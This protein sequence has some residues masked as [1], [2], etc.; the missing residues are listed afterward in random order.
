MLD[1]G[2]F[3]DATPATPAPTVDIFGSAPLE[4]TADMAPTAPVPATAPPVVETVS[5]DEDDALAASAAPPPPATPVDPFAAEGLLGDLAETPLQGFGISSSKYEYN[6]SVMAPL[7]IVTAQ[8][9]QK[10]GSCPATSPVSIT[11][12]KVSDLGKF[13]KECESAGLHLVEAISAT[14]E[15]ICAGMVEGGSKIV[16]IH[17]KI[18]PQGTGEAK[19]DITVKSTDATLSGSLALF[20]QNMMK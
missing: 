18:S 6:G 12:H 4:P 9:G 13:M 3:G 16:L 14:N 10:W 11:S 15:G 20:L 17:G 7:K 2:G 19:V 5:E 8:F 1:L